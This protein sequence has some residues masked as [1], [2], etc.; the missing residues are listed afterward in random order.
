MCPGDSF[1][2]TCTIHVSGAIAIRWDLSIP[3]HGPFQPAFFM[4]DPD[5]DHESEKD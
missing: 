2:V 1:E 3:G 4:M 5:N